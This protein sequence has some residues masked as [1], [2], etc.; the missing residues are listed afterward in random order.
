MR[1]V[2]FA[3][4]LG[5]SMSAMGQVL[6]VTSIE[7]VNL[8]EQAAV[9]AISPQGDY[10]LLTSA[11]NQGLTKLDLTSGQ[12]T[13]LSTAASAGHNVKISPDGQTVVYREG[14]FN[15][16]HLR[17]SSLKS[18][19]LATGESQVLV[20][21]TR[22]LQGYAVDGTTAAIVTKGKYSKKA[23][24][25]AKAEKVPVLSVNKGQLMITL[26]GKT[27]QLSPNGTQFSYMW[28]SISPDGTKVLFYQAAH[29]TYVCDLDGSNVRKVGKM[30]APV[31]Y[32]DNTVVGMMDLDD[33]EFIY[34]S[35]IVAATLDGTI[36]TL[37]DDA[38]IAM[39]PHAIDG[40]I[41]FSTPAGEAYIINVTK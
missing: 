26:N 29:G 10:L 4:A 9:A 34:A 39:Y 40:K 8:P 18:V 5:F 27:R 37:T 41:A 35:T 11:T 20:K 12:T 2:L 19:N 36:Q 23:I 7:K 1:K 17:Y 14:S 32:D 21:P 33:G 6:N 22:D 25:T 16:K 3:L 15:D 13:V 28:A 31:W 30:R 38:T 24:G